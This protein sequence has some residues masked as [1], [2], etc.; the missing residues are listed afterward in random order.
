MAETKQARGEEEMD[1]ESEGGDDSQEWEQRLAEDPEY[2]SRVFRAVEG[3]I[4]DILKRTLVTGLGSTL[5]NEDGLRSLLAEKKLPKEAMGFLMSQAS[6]MR[7]EILRIISREIRM[8]LEDMDFGGEVSKILTTLSFEIKTEIRFIP[9]D[10][11]VKPSIRNRV[12]IKRAGGEG[13]EGEGEALGGGESREE[14]ASAPEAPDHGKVR[15]KL[16]WGLR[17]RADGSEG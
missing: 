14:A 6:G 3:L 13:E 9:N 8:F 17:P 2:A 4:P 15:S 12:K 10:A 7:K 16:R 11:A 5:L 1:E